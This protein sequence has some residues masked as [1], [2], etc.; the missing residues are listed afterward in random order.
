[1]CA[2]MQK[3]SDGTYKMSLPCNPNTPVPLVDPRHDTG[4]FVRALLQVGPG[5]NLYAETALISWTEYMR[6][7]SS[8]MEVQGSYEEC[9][10][11]SWEQ[12]LPGG[13]GKE[14]AD[15]IHYMGTVGYDGGD[16]E[17]VRKENVSRNLASCDVLLCCREQTLI[18]VHE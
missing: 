6:I 5:I 1:M 9:S 18:L 14:L 4:L 2:D 10:R 7:W 12:A 8:I 13:L 17:S 11:E 16:P 15:M 3:M